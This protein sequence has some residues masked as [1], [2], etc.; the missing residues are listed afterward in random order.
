MR[1]RRDIKFDKSDG[2]RVVE[3]CSEK[4][5]P[6]RIS[7]SIN[8]SSTR[9][10]VRAYQEEHNCTWQGKVSL[11]TI[12][13]LQIST[14]RNSINPNISAT[15]LQQKLQRRNINVSKAICERTMLK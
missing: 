12:L 7:G 3:V 4:K 15:Q 1:K 2:K 5:C 9:V 14:L 13:G 11:L 6:W 10:F 8:R